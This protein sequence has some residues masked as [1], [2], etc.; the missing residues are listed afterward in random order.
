M[1][2]VQ[3][4]C[5]SGHCSRKHDEPPGFVFGVR[6][7]ARGATLAPFHTRCLTKVQGARWAK[8][9]GAAGLNHGL[10]FPTPCRSLCAPDFVNYQNMRRA[11]RS[12][13]CG[14][15]AS[16]AC[17]LNVFVLKLVSFAAVAPFDAYGR[18]SSCCCSW[19]QIQLSLTMCYVRYH[20][21]LWDN[22]S[23]GQL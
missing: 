21:A 23:I 18:G 7:L 9:A 12:R 8:G 14:N 20:T 19:Y 16:V 15:T 17:P 22:C 4:A 5:S 6:D 10:I 2:A 13:L 1:A 3:W 11:G